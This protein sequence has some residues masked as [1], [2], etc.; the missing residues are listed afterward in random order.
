MR[1]WHRAA[2]PLGVA[3]LALSGALAGAGPSE[4]RPALRGAD[5]VCRFDDP[6]LTEISGLA[7]SVRH[8]GVLWL[9]NDSSG[10]P[11]LFAVDAATCRTLATVRVRGSQARDYEAIAA[12]RDDRGRAVLWLADIGDNQDS[13]SSVEIVR[14]REPRTL[15]DRSV[16]ST[17]FRFAY[18]D[19]PHNAEALLADPASPRLWVVTKQLAHG[20]LYRLPVPLRPD[21]L[22]VATRL[23]EEGGL[24]TDGAVAPDGSRYVLR[25]YFDATIYAGLP[26]G[27]MLARIP[28]PAQAQ[29]EAI[30]WSAD[31]LSL[32]IA[33]E[34]D[35]RL[36]RVPL[37][38][39]LR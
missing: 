1:P 22:N 19:R 28:L 14:V 17:I 21:R 29:G 23:R 31:G 39:V 27:R 32:L 15:R 35:D 18:R 3:A 37:P 8:P 2:I 11:R 26:P 34:R 13:W 7:T 10:G 36:I 25:D 24:V 9:H 20:S 38:R 16:R 4:A 33:S 5:V 6:R 30:A 12:G